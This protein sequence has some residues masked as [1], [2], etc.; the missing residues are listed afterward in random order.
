[1][2]FKPLR[3]FFTLALLVLASGCAT[4]PS[5]SGGSNTSLLAGAITVST[6]SYE[7]VPPATLDVDTTKLLGQ[8][9]PSGAKV[10][11]LWGL[12]T[13]HDY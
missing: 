1:M 11:L 9:A 10:S 8:G 7:P 2:N 12:I 4:H 3:F 13:I 6:K 5:V